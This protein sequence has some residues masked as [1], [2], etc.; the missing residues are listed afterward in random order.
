MYLNR[1]QNTPSQK[2]SQPTR[3]RDEGISLL[4]IVWPWVMS[5]GLLS[6]SFLPRLYP[7][8]LIALLILCNL[9]AYQVKA[10]RILSVFLFGALWSTGYASWVLSTQLGD[11]IEGKE[12][13][14]VGTIIGVPKLTDRYARFDFKVEALNYRGNN[15]NGPGKIRL[16]WYDKNIPH[17]SS[18]AKWQFLAK[19]KKPHGFANPATFDYEAWLFSQRI[20]ATG[21]VRK[22]ETARLISQPSTLGIDPFRA[23]FSRWL[24]SNQLNQSAII[25]A[26]GVGIK[27]T[28]SDSQWT[29]L[30]NTGTNHLIAISGLHIGLVAGFLYFISGFLWKH[31]LLTR[32][33]YPTQKA[34]W[35]FVLLGAVVYAALAGF[36]IPTKRAMIML[37][38]VAAL[39]FVGRRP[40][41][42]FSLG[43][44]LALVLLFDPLA[45]LGA[46][47]WLSFLAVGFILLTINPIEASTIENNRESACQRFLRKQTQRLISF[48]KIQWAL[49]IGLAPLLLITFQKVS[50]VSVVANFIAVPVIGLLVVPI[51]LVGVVLFSLNLST[52]SLWFI[53]QADAVLNYCWPYLQTL[54]E[55]TFAVWQHSI[56]WPIAVCA[57]I[58]SIGILMHRFGRWRLIFALAWLPAILHSSP[59][60]KIGELSLSVLDVGQG[61]AVVV[62]TANHTLLYDAGPRF[63][64]GF[65]A[66]K[67]IVVPYLRHQGV[68]YLSK[69][70]ISHN[71]IDHSGG[72]NAVRQQFVN[73]E[74]ISSANEG[75]DKSLP[76][77]AGNKWTWDD[78]DF[79]FIYPN[80]EST[81]IGNNASCVLKINTND[82]SVLLTGDIEK[83]AESS[84]LDSITSV[85][86]LDVDVLIAPHHGSKSSSTEAFIKAVSPKY[87]V[88]S[89]GYKNR[90]GHPHPT[91]VD[92]Y[93]LE[94]ATPYNTA[95]SG[96]LIFKLTKK[97]ISSSAF[98]E[99]RP[100]YWQTPILKTN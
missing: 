22:P 89:A 77:I 38:T 47:F 80:L 96:R 59:A 78:V 76:C 64:G 48:A 43:L 81:E 16:R 65:D 27:Q 34:A 83:K 56:T 62:Q 94:G 52:S 68:P 37:I 35:F 74:L 33:F 72:L 91:V 23:R 95:D 2:A 49:L 32:T 88:V 54:S 8:L 21:Y 40:G 92:L 58:G 25:S 29:T 98:R 84:I 9:V 50:L 75:M 51:V 19:L 46:G 87:V 11:E 26:L 1:D 55:S 93:N 36:A 20:R 100:H 39:F 4:A 60:P 73:L 15:H 85:D 53:Q 69:I 31:T 57:L 97:G 6:V 13:Q 71:N 14:V 63:E 7:V 82:G 70:V 61:L 44:V 17:L 28:V 79:E 30:Q 90:Y 42:W 66:G 67:S 24:E 10:F 41:A 45:P 3:W 12:V 86:L 99:E 18:G 5:A